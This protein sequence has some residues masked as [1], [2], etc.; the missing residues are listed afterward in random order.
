MEPDRWLGVEI[1]PSGRAAR[2]SPTEGSFGR[3]AEKLGYTQSAI[4]QQIATLERIVGER[5]IE[6]PGGSR[7]VDADRGRPAPAPPR[8][9]DRRAPPGRAGRPGG[10]VARAR[11]ARSTI[12]TIQSVGARR[13]CRRCMRRFRTSR[14][15]TSRSSCASRTSIASSPT[16]SSAASSTSPSCSCRSA[17]PSLETLEVLRDDYVLVILAGLAARRR[18]PADAAR[19]RR[20]AADRLP[21]LPCDRDPRRTSLRADRARAALRHP[22]GRQ[23]R[24]CRASP[25]PG[26]ASRI[27]PRLAVDANDDSRSRIVELGPSNRAADRRDRPPPRPLPL[28]GRTGVRRDGARERPRAGGAARRPETESLAGRPAPSCGTRNAATP[29]S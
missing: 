13:S 7:P 22:L 18:P 11:P 15:R 2:R 17:N 28:G 23:R 12:G 25:A 24:S 29:L 5:L 20:A 14:G 26:S 4:S 3:A 1:A 10:A 6:R 16:S 8:G 21:Q 19:D 9:V 27:V